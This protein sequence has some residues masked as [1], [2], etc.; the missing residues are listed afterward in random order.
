MSTTTTMVNNSKVKILETPFHVTGYAVGK[1]NDENQFVAF[2]KV[3][4]TVTQ[5][6]PHQV[7]LEVICCSICHTDWVTFGN[8][9]ATPGHEIVGIVKAIGS[10]VEKEGKIKIGMRV[11]AGYQYS[12]CKH[13]ETCSNHFENICNQS[14]PFYLAPIQGGYQSGVV[15]DAHFVFPIPEKLPSIYAAPLLC[16]GATVFSALHYFGENTNFKVKGKKLVCGVLGL[17]G[18]GHLALQYAKKMG[19]HVVGLSTSKDKEEEVRSFGADEF[20]LHNTKEAEVALNEKFDILLNTVSANID[21]D[22]FLRM[23]RPFG[24]LCMLGLSWEPYKFTILPIVSNNRTICGSAIGS[25][26]DLN[27]MLEFSAEHGIK[28]T[29]ELSPLDDVEKAIVRVHENKARYRIVLVINEEQ[30]K[31]EEKKLQIQ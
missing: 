15:W 4:R 31:A 26:D 19:Y 30:V 20:Y 12:S 17:G 16:A 21:I 24:K 3:N 23:L 5:L 6:E 9:G 29:I 25:P 18:L 14:K 22:K 8:E 11:G 2:E 27:R 28:P 1:K 10:E 7:F 13:C